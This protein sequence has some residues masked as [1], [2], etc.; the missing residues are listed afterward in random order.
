MAKSP[1]LKARA[2]AVYWFSRWIKIRDCLATTGTLTEGICIT[3]GRRIRFSQGDCG[4]FVP[5]RADAVLFDENNAH[6]QSS[7]DNRFKQGK[8]IEYEKA[9][10]FMYGAE[11]VQ[12]LKE[13]YYNGFKYS[14]EEYR[15]IAKKY[16][17]GF[18]EICNEY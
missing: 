7:S 18:K 11:E 15:D 4:H 2:R 13:L 6:F 8:W 16:R 12:R 5:G 1:R 14:E 9:L 17:L 10:L 3:S